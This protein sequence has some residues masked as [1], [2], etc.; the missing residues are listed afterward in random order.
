MPIDSFARS[1]SRRSFLAGALSAEMTS[2]MLQAQ[3]AQEPDGPEANG[4]NSRRISGARFDVDRFVEDC[5]NANR[6]DDSGQAVREV[7]ERAMADPRSV[8]LGLGEPAQGGIHPLYRSTELT[9]LN[10]IWPPLMQLMPHEHNMWSVIGIYTGRE[11]NIFWRENGETINAFSAAAIDVGK[12]TPLSRGVIHSVVNPTEKLTGALH[13]YGGDFFE[14][15]RR[16][17]D[18]ET[19]APHTWDLEKAMRLFR[20]STERFDLW[21]TARGEGR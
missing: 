2:A 20:E 13:I 6:E 16:E 18:P 21:R 15:P 11:D 17:W 3:G 19:L 8:L 10:I 14:K 5:R 9:V 4:R 12:A 1:F 7:F